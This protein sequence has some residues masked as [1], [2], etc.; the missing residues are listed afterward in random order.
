VAIQQGSIWRASALAAL[1]LVMPALAGVTA[2]SAL[3]ADKLRVGKAIAL[4]IDFTPLD[5][6]IEKGFY[7]KHGL[8]V[9]AINFA[10]SA[11]L[12]QGLAANAVDIGLGSGPELAFVAKGNTDLGIAAFAGPANGLFLIVRPDAGVNSPA[13]LKG[14]K[15]GVSTVGGLTDWMTHQASVKQGWGTDGIRVTPLGSDEAQVAALKTKDLDGMCIDVAGAYTLQEAHEAKIILRFGDIVPDFINHITYA[16][17]K[18]IA[19][20]PDEVRAF[21]AGWFE[22]VAWMRK[23]KD[24]TVKLAAPVMHKSPAIAARAYDEVMPSLSDTG[25]FDP[26]ALKVLSKSF[27]DMKLLDKEPDMSKLYTEKFLPGAH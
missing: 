16:S 6:G 22:T 12:Q 7:K 2:G 11:K 14:K 17:N 15:I 4:P 27:I 9:E 19:E 20:H 18:I 25:K 13:D 8:D 21:L 1:A 3:A 24:E 23:N 10:G 26:K 5:I